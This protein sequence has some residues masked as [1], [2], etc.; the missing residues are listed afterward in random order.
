V[1]PFHEAG[2]PGRAGITLLLIGVLAMTSCNKTVE[3]TPAGGP[4]GDIYGHGSLEIHSSQGRVELSVRIA[5]TPAAKAK[6]LMGEPTLAQN[7]G[8]VFTYEGPTTV[9][10]WMKDTR[11]P[12][13]IA[14]WDKENRIVDILDMEPCTS[15]PCPLYRSSSPYLGAVEVNRGFFERHGVRIGDAVELNTFGSL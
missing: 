1:T 11:I 4:G 3:A 2:S 13:S 14:Y 12:L 6:G 8:M 15:G 7:A 5:S 9:P 10:F